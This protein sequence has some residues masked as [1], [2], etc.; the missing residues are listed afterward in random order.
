MN[1]NRLETSLSILLTAVAVVSAAIVVGRGRS[2]TASVQAL[3]EKVANW[4]DAFAIG[5]R[6]GDSQAPITIVEVA[7]L[8][9]PVCR[10][11]NP[12]VQTVLRENPGS[13]ALIHVAYPLSY[14]EQ[15]MAAARGAEC[16]AARGHF[17]DWINVVYNKQ[18]SLGKKSWAS[19]AADAGLQDTAAIAKCAV[20]NGVVQR[21]VQGL[22]YGRRIGLTG[23]PTI[24]VNGW[25]LPDPPTTDKLRAIVKS[26]KAG[27][28]PFSKKAWLE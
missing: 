11:F 6:I 19:Y 10:G 3:P 2:A 21:I 1:A 15:A 22:A 28:N 23:T 13:V 18:D 7:D 9:C 4:K 16:A 27:G 20:S 8:Q 24:I 17:A 26:L 14:H 5:Y 25:R 12:V